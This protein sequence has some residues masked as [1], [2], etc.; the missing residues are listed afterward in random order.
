MIKYII[1]GVV[2]ILVYGI[3]WG[4]MKASGRKTPPMPDMKEEEKFREK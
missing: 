1:I 3:F 4:L 2:I